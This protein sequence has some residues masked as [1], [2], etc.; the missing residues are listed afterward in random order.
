MGCSSIVV[1][2]GFTVCDC[3]SQSYLVDGVS[4]DIDT[5][6]SDWAS[7][8]VTVRRNEGTA[9]TNL[10]YVLLTFGFDTAVSLTEIEMDLFHCPEM[11]ISAP[12]IT[13]YVNE[14]YDLTFRTGLRSLISVAPSESRCDS[15][16][17]FTTSDTTD[18]LY[19]V[20]HI[21][22]T[23]PDSNIDWVYVGEVRFLGSSDTGLFIIGKCNSMLYSLG[24][25]STPTSTAVPSTSL[26]PSNTRGEFPTAMYGSHFY[27]PIL[28]F[29]VKLTPSSTYTNGTCWLNKMYTHKNVS[30]IPDQPQ[31]TSVPG[32]RGNDC[33]CSD[34]CSEET[35]TMIAVSAV[36][37]LLIV[38]LTTVTLTQCIL[39]RMRR[40]RDRSETY[41]EATNS[42]TKTTDVP[43]S[44]NEAYALT[45]IT[46][47]EVTYELVK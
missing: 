23:F 9:D 34:T 2:D 35:S 45:K 24:L 14:E 7:Q 19:H 12:H 5:S 20:V 29:T 44:L 38:T 6:T 10:D 39:I 41:A 21:L 42:T 47:E 37:L 4:P 36:S 28:S 16:S 3:N 22:I 8:L 18:L 11:S 1:R 30:C 33:T 17:S 15:L 31:P 26:S 25:C 43:V 40:S 13:V 27:G 46:T 32:E